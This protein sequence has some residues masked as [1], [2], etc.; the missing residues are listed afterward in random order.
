M[1][2]SGCSLSLIRIRTSFRPTLRDLFS[3]RPTLFSYKLAL[4]LSLL[5]PVRRVQTGVLL[6]ACVRQGALAS[7][8]RQNER[9]P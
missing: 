4:Q 3:S 9:V 2:Q 5:H 7:L 8:F 1:C 6:Q